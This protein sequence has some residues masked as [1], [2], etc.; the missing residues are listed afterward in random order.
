MT[1]QRPSLDRAAEL[2]EEPDVLDRLRDDPMTRVIVVREGRVRVVDSALLRVPPAAV[3]EATWALLGR[4]ADGSV[5][6][7]AAAPP[8]TEALDA[9]PDEIWLGLRDLGGRIDGQES[10]LLIGAIALAGWLRD[11]PFCPTCGGGTELQQAGW[12]RRCLVCG[13]QHF[14][15]TDPAVIVAV[16]SRD[17]ERLLLGANAN[18]GGRMFSCFAGFT[19]AGESLESTAYREIEEESGVRLSALR[20]ISSQ[21][22]PFPRSLMVG[23][24]AIVDDESAARPDGEEI[25]EVRWFTRAEIGSALA[26]D[27]PVGLPGPASIARALIIDW[28]EDR[29]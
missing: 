12:S 2:R 4:D 17:G 16:E 9:A 28:Y 15:R 26:G 24:R 21:A 3:V 23:F 14:P 10:E 25:I 27:G 19:E 22:W 29:A 11:A 8:E 7:L 13:R 18:W 6:L 5:L 1:I 20:Y